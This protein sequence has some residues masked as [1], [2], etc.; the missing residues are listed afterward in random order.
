MGYFIWEFGYFKEGAMVIL[1]GDMRLV[2]ITKV[3]GVG[4]NFIKFGVEAFEGSFK[5]EM[6][7]QRMIASISPDN[8]HLTQFQHFKLQN[9]KKFLKL[10]R[11][12]ADENRDWDDSKM[13]V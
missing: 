7:V 6:S 2:K 5:D 3:E 12:V 13:Q 8:F 10:M 1:G 11:D 4:R 9:L